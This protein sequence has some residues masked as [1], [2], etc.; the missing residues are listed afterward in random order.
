MSFRRVLGGILGAKLAAVLSGIGRGTGG[1][2]LGGAG[3][4]VVVP[5][6][7]DGCVAELPEWRVGNKE[8]NVLSGR[9]L[10]VERAINGTGERNRRER[11]R[12]H[13]ANGA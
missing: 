2:G 10:L 4:P 8:C 3:L 1:G 7:A 9:V 12:F 13:T 5:C 6:V 11:A